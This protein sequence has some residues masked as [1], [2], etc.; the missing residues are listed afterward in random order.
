MQIPTVHPFPARMAPEL[1]LTSL[2]SLPPGSIVLDPM[3]GSGTVL[4]QALAL[5]YSAVGFDMDPL[6]VLMSRVWT[7][8]IDATIVLHERRTVMREAAQ[9]DLRYSQPEWH[10]VETREFIDY[11]F[12]PEQRRAL[13]RLAIVLHRRRIASLGP[14][15]R[16]AVDVLQIALSRI[17]ITKEQCASLARDT[18]HSRPHRVSLESNY[19][20]DAGFSRSVDQVIKRLQDLPGKLGGTN[21]RS[22]TVTLG[23]ARQMV[24]GDHSVDA[25][26]TSPPYLNAI[27]YMRGH[28]LSL[29]WLGHRLNDL[30]RIRSNSIGAERGD[31]SADA[32]VEDVAGAMCD[33]NTLAPRHRR[34]VRRYANDL[35]QMMQ[36]AARVLR[37]SGRA[38]YVLGNSC[39][40]DT[41]IQNSAGVA[42]AGMHAGL[43]LL[44]E[45]ERDLPA[46]SRYLPITATG[47]LSKR[48][49]TETI[50]TF[51][52]RVV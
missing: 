41:F 39:L 5:G 34:M 15:R 1:A 27:D 16:A 6:A 51:S 42:R 28:R 38:T 13:T 49:R 9:V 44:N 2:E 10:D 52:P 45:T 31:E 11:W 30:R 47:K 25:I 8:Q 29:V 22:A 48:M 33:L 50:L 4:R 37:P 12:A 7:T 17:I 43:R 32:N 20:I 36:Q 14:V 21:A 26:L 18:S 46:A 24:L 19:D 3:T 40:R 35:I 23:D